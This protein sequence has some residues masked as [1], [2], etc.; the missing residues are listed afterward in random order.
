MMV[1]GGGA[2]SSLWRQILADVLNQPLHH[3]IGDSCLGAAIIAAVGIGLY[4]SVDAAVGNM[5]PETTEVLP[6]PEDVERYEQVYQDFGKKR[7]IL[8][9]LSEAW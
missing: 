9:E 1:T 2:R 8:F 4:G 5:K 6:H 3:S 7:D